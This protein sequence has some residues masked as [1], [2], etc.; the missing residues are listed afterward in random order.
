MTYMSKFLLSMIILISILT[1]FLH[2]GTVPPVLDSSSIGFR[3]I[4]AI[5]N[6]GTLIMLYFL[7]RKLFK[8]EK[9][10][11]LSSFIFG[12]LPWTIEQSRVASEVNTFLFWLILLLTISIS[13]KFKFIKVLAIVL[14]PLFLYVTYPSFWLF[15]INLYSFNLNNFINNIFLLT[16]FELLF[17]RNITFWW[18]GLREWGALHISFIPFLLVGV[19]Q[20]LVK[21][22]IYLIIPIILILIISALSPYLPESREFYIVTPFISVIL[23]MG[24][25]YFFRSYSIGKYRY[26]AIIIFVFA[27]IYDFS[28]LLHY[29]FVHYSQQVIGNIQ[30]IHGIF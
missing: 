24:I 10:S 30:N 6:I 2:L 5:E 3:T 23:A 28:S 7:T 25:L 29:Y 21:R 26:P 9:I 19:F 4:S 27:F 16:S 15:K 8:N 17:F 12:L 20:L 11:L 13:S 14:I 1:R 18:G 22:I